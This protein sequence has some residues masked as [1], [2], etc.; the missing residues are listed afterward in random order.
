[1]ILSA[2]PDLRSLPLRKALTLNR[3]A[4][5]GVSVI[6]ASGPKTKPM[7]REGIAR[8]HGLPILLDASSVPPIAQSRRIRLP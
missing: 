5:A 3:E 2:T 7:S 6:S 4:S 8:N 1:M